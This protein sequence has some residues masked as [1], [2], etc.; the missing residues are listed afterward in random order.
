MKIVFGLIVVLI[1]ILPISAT[2]DSGQIDVNAAILEELDQLYGIGPAKAQAIVDARPFSDLD[3]L[4]RVN[5]IGEITLENLKN[6][7]LACVSDESEDKEEHKED[8]EKRE[9]EEMIE[10]VEEEKNQE[11]KEVSEEEPANNP[12]T[13]E[14]IKLASKDINKEESKKSLQDYSLYG[15]IGFCVVMGILLYLRNKRY[16][17]N[18]FDE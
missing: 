16:N 1:F 7:G 9:Q 8:E 13:F 15:V 11:S 5:G 4:I 3:D 2:C 17:K 12:V 18:E 14:T 10:E 6:Q